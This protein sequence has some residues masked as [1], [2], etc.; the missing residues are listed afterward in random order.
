MQE[1]KS[2]RAKFVEYGVCFSSGVQFWPKIALLKILS[3][4]MHCNNPYLDDDLLLCCV[5]FVF[6]PFLFQ[7]WCCQYSM[8]ETQKHM[9]LCVLLTVHFSNI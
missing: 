5:L 1:G 2:Y 4:K 9:S 6:S 3:R 8:P 7:N